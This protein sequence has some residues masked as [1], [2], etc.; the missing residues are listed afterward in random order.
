M[1]C[2]FSARTDV[3]RVRTNN[4]D[5]VHV[6]AA[7][8]LVVLADGM[9]GYSAGEVASAMAIESITT[10]LGQWLDAAQADTPLV[11]VQRAVERCIAQANR[12]IFEAANTRPDCAG[13]GTTV[14]VALVWNRQLVVAHVGDSRAYHWRR[15]ILNQLT[16]DHS[17]LQEQLD[18]GLITPL[19]A[20]QSSY[21]SL[22]T[23]ALGVED[24]VQV[25]LQAI[26]LRGGETI[27]LCS[28]GLT[29]MV[30]D[31]EIASVLDADGGLDAKAGTLIDLANA[32]GGRDNVSVILLHVQEMAKM[33]GFVNR[34]IR[35]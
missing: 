33:S 6:D 34:L 22:I 18:A 7:R 30:P 13:M 11:S 21:R 32:S 16:R 19:E 2:E 15:G 24:T 28:D 31:L 20:A 26:D 9:G 25:D 8:R 27:L 10:E 4:E 5:A 14:V 35:K 1:D 12:A 3:G 29:E 23:R 17:L